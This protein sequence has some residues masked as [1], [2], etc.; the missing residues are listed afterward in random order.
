MTNL[1]NNYTK[2]SE[3]NDRIILYPDSP[4]LKKML[5]RIYDR[6]DTTEC[7]YDRW[8]TMN[9]WVQKYRKGLSFDEMLNCAEAELYG[10]WW[11]HVDEKTEEEIYNRKIDVVNMIIDIANNGYDENKYSSTKDWFPIRVSIDGMGSIWSYDGAHRTMI[12]ASLSMET[13]CKIEYIRTNF[14]ESIL[15]LSMLYQPSSHPCVQNLK[16]IRKDLERYKVISNV[17]KTLNIKSVCEIG[18][19]EGEGA[20]VLA[21][22]GANITGIENENA[23]LTLARA[24]NEVS[25]Q[26][27]I[28]KSVIDTNKYDAYVGLSVW[29]HLAENLETLNKWIDLTK[30]ANFQFIEM[31]ETGSKTYKQG[32]IDD[33]GWNWENIGE[34]ITQHLMQR[35]G[36]TNSEILYVDKKYANRKTILLSK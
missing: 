13:P 16:V 28:L 23:R 18:C 14:L 5:E 19:A 35:G 4:Y 27:I 29:H 6:W 10:R 36:Y 2:G 24:L 20:F 3:Y 26:K 33:T 9:N 34:E 15:P 21:E 11:S 12:L 1:M 31:P 32:L 30:H 8:G 22:S 25:R 17:I 7:I